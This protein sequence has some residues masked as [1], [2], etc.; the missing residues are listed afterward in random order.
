[1]AS[2]IYT[3]KDYNYEYFTGANVSIYGNGSRITECSGIS[4]SI[5][6]SR[7]PVYGYN[8]EYFDVMLPGRIIVQGNILINYTGPNYLT[9]LLNSELANGDLFNIE[10][11]FGDRGPSH[12]NRQTI[13]DCALISSGNTIQI[14][15]Q[16][17]LE[18][19]SFIAKNIV[20]V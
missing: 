8:S 3:T 14:N 18:E 6:N 1:M 12:G 19:Y 13:V 7:Q 4:Y 17:I 15:E 16:V 9:R 10:V 5:T 2:S 11:N 20:G